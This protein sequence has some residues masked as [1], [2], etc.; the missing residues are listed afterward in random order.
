MF[1]GGVRQGVISYRALWYLFTKGKKVV[2]KTD[3][4]FSVGAGTP[5]RLPTTGEA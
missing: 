4:N 3:T 5:P 2:G 1:G